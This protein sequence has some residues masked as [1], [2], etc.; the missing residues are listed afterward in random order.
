MLHPD[1]DGAN[2][3]PACHV[4]ACHEHSVPPWLSL[5]A[6]GSG[7]CRARACA[8]YSRAVGHSVWGGE[9]RMRQVRL[10]SVLISAGG[11]QGGGDDA[12]LLGWHQRPQGAT[13]PFGLFLFSQPPSTTRCHLVPAAPLCFACADSRVACDLQVG[14]ISGLVETDSGTHIILRTE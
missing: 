14:E 10:T 9:R 11:I 4:R 3:P 7:S 12:A 13:S 5:C 8:S 2:M 1:V 6:L